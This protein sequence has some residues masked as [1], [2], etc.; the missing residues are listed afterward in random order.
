MHADG[1]SKD[2]QST[3]DRYGKD[4]GALTCIASHHLASP[5]KRT[6]SK[7][8]FAASPTL[9]DSSLVH[10]AAAIELIHEASIVH[11]DIQDRTEK[12]RGQPTVWHKY[13][14]NAALLLGD[15]LVAA[16]FR[17]IAEYP[18][19]ASVQGPLLATLSQAVSRAAS[20]QHLQLATNIHSRDLLTVYREVAR[21]KTGAF[22]ALPLQFAAILAQADMAASAHARRCGEQLGLAYQILDDLRPYAMP[23]TLVRHEDIIDRVITAPVAAARTLFPKQDPFELVLHNQHRRE[24]ALQ[25]CQHWLED[26]LQEAKCNADALPAPIANVVT[27]FISDHLNTVTNRSGRGQNSYRPWQ[28]QHAASI[29]AV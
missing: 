18:F 14:A 2:L 9:Q 15:H 12:R 28:P 13:G 10:A 8:L 27:H 16:A 17:A 22:I 3:I 29:K 6:R 4:A 19:P 7:L 23:A 21:H 5:G 1:N 20:G 11:D 25:R 26:A 24:Q